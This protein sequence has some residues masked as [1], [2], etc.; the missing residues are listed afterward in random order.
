MGKPARKAKARLKRRESR[1]A[2]LAKNDKSN[3]YPTPGS[4]NKHKTSA[5]GVGKKR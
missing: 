5:L 2:A 1:H 4:Q 3:A